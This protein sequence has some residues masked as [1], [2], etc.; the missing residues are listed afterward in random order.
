[1]LDVFYKNNS[2]INFFWKRHEWKEGRESEWEREI[3]HSIASALLLYLSIV[4]SLP[5]HFFF[6]HVYEN[7]CDVC[8]KKK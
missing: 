5:K 7:E 1:M 6:L 2:L 8:L 4:V 3:N